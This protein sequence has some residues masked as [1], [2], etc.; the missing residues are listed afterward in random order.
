MSPITIFLTFPEISFPRAFS[1][2]DHPTVII[3]LQKKKKTKPQTKKLKK[4]KLKKKTK[5]LKKK[6]SN[7]NQTKTKKYKQTTN[8][9]KTQPEQAKTPN[10]NANSQMQFNICISFFHFW[11]N[12][13]CK[14]RGLK[15]PASIISFWRKFITRKSNQYWNS[16]KRWKHVHR[17]RP[18]L[19]QAERSPMENRILNKQQKTLSWR[20]D[21]DKA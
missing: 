2:T 15:L 6:K 21:Q 4:K 13:H 17:L 7:K 11:D 14:N 12:N 5:P 10:T 1:L 8:P 9:N 18:K 19:S 3:S 20:T 16:K